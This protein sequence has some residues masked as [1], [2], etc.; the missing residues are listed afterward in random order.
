MTALPRTFRRYV[1]IGDSSTEGL[2]DPDGRGGYHGWANRLAVRVASAQASPLLYANLAIR[3]RSTRQIREQ[4]LE[5]ALALNPDLVTLF[6]GTNDV[7]K[8]KFDAEAVGRDVELMQQRLIENGATVLGFTLPDL[9]IV[10]PIARPIAGRVR[11]LND[12][13]RQASTSTG[14]IL[15]DFA[16]HSV[17]SDP[18]LW[19]ADRLHANS[20]GHERIAAALAWALRLPGTDETWSHPLPTEWSQSLSAAVAAELRWQRAYFLPWVWRHLWG[21]SSGDGRGC[22]RPT[23][24]IVEPDLAPLTRP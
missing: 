2:D 1:A 7:V 23:L 21:R 4:Q 16:K 13:L 9:S 8:P 5:P 22:K 14:A 19:S 11:A 3:G 18:R 15:V 24:T 20:T 10:L 12:A 17:G 6:T